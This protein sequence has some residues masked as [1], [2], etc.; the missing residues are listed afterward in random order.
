MG[1]FVSAWVACEF[2]FLS[3]IEAEAMDLKA[4]I[5]SAIEMNLNRVNFESDSQVMVQAIHS[6]LTGNST[7]I[8]LVSQ[9]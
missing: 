9:L 2:S 8:T 7:F 3:I 5:L 4:A 6:R 1:E